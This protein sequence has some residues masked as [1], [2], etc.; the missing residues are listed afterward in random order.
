[1]DPGCVGKGPGTKRLQNNIIYKYYPLLLQ[2]HFSWTK[3]SEQ[4]FLTRAVYENHLGVFLNYTSLFEL[5]HCKKQAFF[6]LKL[7][8][9]DSGLV[10]GIR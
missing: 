8:K 10:G 5:L 9:S 4:W 2:G 6:F 7:R 3:D 1:M